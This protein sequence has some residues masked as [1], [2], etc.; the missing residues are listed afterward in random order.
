MTKYYLGLDIGTNSVGWSVTDTEYNVINKNKKRLMGVELFEEANTAEER[1][2]FRSQRRRLNRRNWRLQLLKDEFEKEIEKV[3][4]DFLLSLQESKYHLEDKKIN[5]KYILFNDKNY[6]D[7]KFHKDYPTHYHLREAMKTQKNPDIRK[8]YLALH[9][10]YKSRGH[11]LFEEQSFSNGTIETTLNELLTTLN[12]NLDTKKVTEICL[13]KDNTTNKVKAFKEITNDK[14]IQEIFRLIFGGS[15]SLDKLYNMD[16]YKELDS[17]VKRI[18]FK[19]KNYDEVRHEYETVLNDNIELLDKIKL[20]YDAI[21]LANIKKDGLSLSKSKIEIYN[22]HKR[23]R[24]NLKKLIMQEKSLTVKERKALYYNIMLKDEKAG[25]NY[26]NYTRNSDITKSCDYESFKKFL[27]KELS[28]L[29]DTKQKELIL[30]DI[31]QDTFL[32][33]LRT[34]DNSVIPYQIHNE[35]LLEIIN[36]AKKYHKFLTEEVIDR[37]IKIFE[38]KIPYFI[39]P[40]N[41]NIENSFAWSVRKT[42]HEHTPITPWNYY[43]V[44][45]ETESAKKFIDNLINN[46]TYLE[47]EKVIPKESLLYSEY[48]LLNEL[49]AIKI[50]NVKITTDI[51]NIIIDELFIKTKTTVTKNKIKQLLVKKQLIDKTAEITGIDNIVKGNLKAKHEFSKILGD[52]FNKE[53]V[54][55]MIYWLTIYGN[56]KKLVKEN[57]ETH[58]PNI[59]TKEQI[60]QILKL[61][62]KDWS[63]L[64]KKFLTEIHSKSLINTE[65]GEI[66]NIIEALRQTN[67]ILMEL[68]SNKFDYTEQIDKLNIKKEIKELTPD[69]LNNLYVS[70]ST[71]RAIWQ[72]L[73]INDRLKKELG[74]EPTKIFI[75]TTRTNQAPKI[76]KDTRH[77]NLINLYSKIKE[78]DIKGLDI[79]LKELKESL[80]KE[81]PSNLKSKKLYLYYL[82]LGKCLYTGK[83]I[84]KNEI[85]SILEYDIDH[86]YPQSKVKDD[87]FDNTV[88]VYRTANANKSDIYPLSESTQ[89]KNKSLWS[90]LKS[91]KLMNDEKYNRLVRT[92]EF[93]NNELSGFITR[94]LVETS[95][96]IKVVS[97]LLKQLNP[98]TRIC[99][100]KA[101][102]VNTFKQNYG[103][104]KECNRKSQNKEQIIKVR[105]LNDLHH[106]VDAY[107]NIV[108]GNVYDTKFTSNPRTFIDSSKDNRKYSLNTLFY[109][110]IKDAWI[111]D[112]TINT[113]DREINNTNIQ[114]N[115]R[116]SRKTGKLFDA[117]IYKANVAKEGVYYPIKTKDERMLDVTKY[118]G[119]TSITISHYTLASYTVTTPKESYDAKYL[120]PVPIYKVNSIKTD[121][122]LL[123]HIESVILHKPNE[124]ISNIKII[125]KELYTHSKVIL[126]GLPVY[127]GGKT[128]NNITYRSALQITFDY[129]TT[130][131]L[132]TM[133]NY[134]NWQKANKGK[135]DLWYSITQDDNLK[136]YDAIIKKMTD[137]LINKINPTKFDMLQDKTYRKTFEKLT[138]DEQVQVLAELLNLITTKL[139]PNAK[140]LKLINMS[141]SV[142]SIPFSLNGYEL[143]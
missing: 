52:N 37:L 65:T 13:S 62:F 69:I 139:T 138:L 108:V 83:N 45:D 21:I 58:Y 116:A 109:Y 124:T 29:K 123:K 57:I 34:K 31:D 110:N 18:S 50:D 121:D 122:E 39:G 5:K 67:Y 103:K 118:G 72:T 111:I 14:Q 63:S 142:K 47:N 16:E 129:D 23:D 113:V 99:Y 95:Q 101:E 12:I 26:V 1:R 143:F 77:Q 78:S 131:Y 46:C 126:N 10:I 61:K 75:E 98:K 120:V 68:L 64:S 91:L 27:K 8:V 97:K 100:S 73:K 135:G 114:V 87:S 104:I 43:E 106:A 15:V 74:T 105:E 30:N 70:P 35:E 127:L 76:V 48:M 107:L 3:D 134:I 11:H 89:E 4:P 132:K 112:K 59:Y 54:E 85:N 137:K 79:N 88:L 128:N 82:Q 7:K 44:I 41:N 94:Q 49:N 80:E 20:V 24:K 6:T 117:T 71:K 55:N 42:G 40:L 136:T 133:F 119:Y 19:N 56:T 125:K 33:L 38:F 2:L 86:I 66:L 84:D 102:N 92:E 17:N 60:D 141:A 53:H 96:T 32:P 140:V 90:T 81:L 9:H 36:N 115:K 93:S 130:R 28:I 25:T 22:K 51:R